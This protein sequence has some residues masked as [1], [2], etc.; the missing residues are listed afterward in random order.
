M[1]AAESIDPG[2]N[3]DCTQSHNKQTSNLSGFKLDFLTSGKGCKT[4]AHGTLQ[5][6]TETGS[7]GSKHDHTE[8]K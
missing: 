4:A 2:V 1:S 7:V 5:C 8:P 3:A 6:F